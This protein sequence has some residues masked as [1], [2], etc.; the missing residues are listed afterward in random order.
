MLKQ[1][2]NDFKLI[3][4]SSIVMED[5]ENP[6]DLLIVTSHILL[7]DDKYWLVNDQ[8]EIEDA[9]YSTIEELKRIHS[10]S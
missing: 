4:S 6:G 10:F 3:E 8:Q 9:G 5:D 7:K 1:I 2:K